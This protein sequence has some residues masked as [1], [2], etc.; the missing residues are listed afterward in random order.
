M[1]RFLAFVGM[2]VGSY[3]GW[4]LGSQVGFVTACFASVLGTALGLYAGRRV[5]QRYGEYFE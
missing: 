5:W 4:W 3:V 2:T 1:K